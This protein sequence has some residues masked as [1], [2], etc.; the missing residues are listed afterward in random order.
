[1]NRDCHYWE[2]GFRSELG[3]NSSHF[4]Q[5]FGFEDILI[6]EPGFNWVPPVNCLEV[7]SKFALDNLSPRKHVVGK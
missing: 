5:A 2:H 1:M 7:A 4:Y 3:Y 6:N